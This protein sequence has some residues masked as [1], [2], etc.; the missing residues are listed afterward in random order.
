MGEKKT[1]Q[2]RMSAAGR[3][4]IAGGSGQGDELSLHVANVARVCVQMPELARRRAPAGERGSLA[5]ARSLDL[6]RE[7]ACTHR[8]GEFQSSV[9]P[10]AGHLRVELRPLR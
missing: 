2:E 9:T 5:G 1:K 7:G 8:P 4:G 10:R 6:P 3:G